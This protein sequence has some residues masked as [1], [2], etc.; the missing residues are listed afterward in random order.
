MPI[1]D[2]TPAVLS[3][4]DMTRAEAWFERFFGH[5]GDANPM[6]ILREWHEGSGGIAVFEQADQAGNGFVTM[7]VDSLDAHR[8]QLAERGQRLSCHIFVPPRLSTR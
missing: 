4:D 5:P 8:A 7:L 6:P 3:T 2:R 1:I